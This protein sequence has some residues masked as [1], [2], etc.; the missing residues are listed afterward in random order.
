MGLLSVYLFFNSATFLRA[1]FD[2]IRL[3]SFFNLITYLAFYTPQ[4]TISDI[5]M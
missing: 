1:S 4:N 5:V 2:V 3:I